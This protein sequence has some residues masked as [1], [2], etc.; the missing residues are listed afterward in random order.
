MTVNF[1]NVKAGRGVKKRLKESIISAIDSLDM[2][3]K[4]PKKVQSDRDFNLY[5]IE[6]K[7]LFES[8][9]EMIPFIQIETISVYK[10]YPC[11][12]K[13]VSNY[14][15]KYLST[16]EEGHDL[17]KKYE[18]ESFNMKI[19][20]IDRTFIDKLFAICD[21]HLAGTYH[22]Y[23]RHI[24]DIHMI[25]NSGLLDTLAL[26]NLALHVLAD[27]QRFYDKNLSSK[28]G[29]KPKVIVKEIIDKEVF[30]KDFNDVTLNFIYKKVDYENCIQSLKEILDEDFF[31]EV[32]GTY[33]I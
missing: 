21:Y 27:R 33:S 14:I 16:L 30:K 25:W 18:L 2:H 23:S 20:S 3:F 7:K 10:P 6:F 19:Q 11:E 8:T 13:L 9:P 17:I 32:V 29:S 1:P 22:R 31:P 26:N 5:E 4:N 15:T 12:K 24:Y 28:P